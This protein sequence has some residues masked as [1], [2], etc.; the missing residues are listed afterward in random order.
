[1]ESNGRG[2]IQLSHERNKWDAVCA[3]EMLPAPGGDAQ[4]CSKGLEG[5]KGCALATVWDARDCKGIDAHVDRN[6]RY[7]RSRTWNPIG[8]FAWMD[9]NV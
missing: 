6:P 5:R 7:T 3:V 4:E 2:H 9:G 8:G 1:M